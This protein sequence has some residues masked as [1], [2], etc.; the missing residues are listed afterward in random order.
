MTGRA[1][2]PLTVLHID[3]E[4]GWRGGERQALWLAAGLAARG[5]RSL[6][7]ARPGEPLA[8]RAAERG[9]E[10]VPCEPFS[11]LDP[12][13]AA[14]LRRVIRRARVDIVHAHTGHAVALGALARR[15]TG[16]RLVLTRRVDFPLKDN[17]GTRWKYRQADAYIGVCG[18]A[19]ES[20]VRAGLDPARVHVVHSGVDFSR[21]VVPASRETLA[22][23]GVRAGSPL[24]VQ[25]AALVEHKDPL[26][27]VRG[28][29]AARRRV[30][31]IQALMVG[32][33]AMRPRVEEEIAARGLRD[34]VHLAG[35][36]T[37]A[38]SLLAAADVATLSSTAEGI[39]GVLIDALSF[40]RPIVATRASGFVEVVSHGE[41]GLLVPIGDAEAFG[42]ALATILHD[43]ALAARLSTAALSAAP[44]FSIENT[45]EGTIGV[46]ERVLSTE[47]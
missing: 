43:P 18:T 45:V 40:G 42:D 4:R 17:L 2:A 23:L 6:V 19:A 21:R 26:T 46:Y 33:G 11:E 28:I 34:V 38:D 8:A 44:R 30:P 47:Y 37:D 24:V 13:A 39:G 32:E 12:L 29:E 41:T 9:L 22:A 5:H 35:Y 27:F 16:A 25:V 10:V 3:T 36:R 14:R 31:H 7:A 1:T 20:L 15:G